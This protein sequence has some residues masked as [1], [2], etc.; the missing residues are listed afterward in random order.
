MM[1]LFSVGE[2][3]VDSTMR[4]V[5]LKAGYDLARSRGADVETAQREAV[6]H[7]MDAMPVYGSWNTP[8]AATTRAP[9]L[10]E[11]VP[12]A[13]QYKLY[14]MS[15]YATM[16]GLVRKAAS[17]PEER[18]EALKA[19][20]GLV[21]SHSILGGV[22]KNLFSLPVV[23]A[24]GAWSF[25]SG[26]EKPHD[27]EVDF[28]RMLY[29]LTGSETVSKFASAGLFGL[30]GADQANSLGLGNMVGVP[31]V[32]SFDKAGAGQF[33]VQSLTGASGDVATQIFEGLHELTSGNFSRAVKELTPRVFSDPKKAFDLATEGVT[34]KRGRSIAPPISVGQAALQATGFNPY[35]ASIAR[36]KRHAEESYKEEYQLS[37]R[38]AI[39]RYVLSG[40]QDMTG[41]RRYMNNDEYRRV[42][43]IKFAQLREALKEERQRERRPE[44]YG[45]RPTK[46]EERPF[47]EATRFY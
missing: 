47:R 35:D 13:M 2:H 26:D 18:G 27:Y 44:F 17:R 46:R 6:R 36:Q 15:M 8:R 12:A 19:L 42:S 7:A 22:T 9:V 31:E 32:R 28:K 14:G 43:P 11:L 5:I 33:L 39:D 4:T 21:A 38:R 1:N 30:A 25:F 3:T 20:A 34:D 40:G 16:G 41:V 29:D 24:L 45:A 10:K 23:A 37:R